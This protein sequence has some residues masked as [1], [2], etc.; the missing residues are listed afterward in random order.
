MRAKY[1]IWIIFILSI[2]LVKA[3]NKTTVTLPKDSTYLENIKKSRL[4]GF[5]IPRDI[6]DALSKLMAL[7]DEEA[8]KP[9][10]TIDEA[11]MA[12]KLYFGLGRWME[13]NWNF[14]EGSRFSH[15][16]RQKGLTHTEDMTRFML[17][18]FHRHINGKPLQT[19]ELI[20]QFVSERKKKIQEEKDKMKVISIEKKP[21]HTKG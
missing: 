12:K 15:Y 8:R 1:L 3:Q 17:I 19:D 13:Y 11:T 9:L 20:A 2:N 6:D 7:T 4:Y 14:E 10:K 21:A 16:L 18:S 5:Y